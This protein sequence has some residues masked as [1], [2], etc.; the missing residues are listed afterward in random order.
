MRSVRKYI[1]KRGSDSKTFHTMKYSLHTV[2]NAQ[3][4]YQLDCGW[5]MNLFLTCVVDDFAA[6]LIIITSQ[7]P[8]NHHVRRSTMDYGKGN[9]IMSLI[10]YFIMVLSSWVMGEHHEWMNLRDV[11]KIHWDN[12]RRTDDAL[13]IAIKSQEPRAKLWSTAP[14]MLHSIILKEC[15]WHMLD[16][17]VSD[18]DSLIRYE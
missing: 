11:A 7:T 12:E 18:V 1:G 16:A 6:I 8:L 17:S 4:N 2:S 9:S 14:P 13:P 10:S 15:Y 5:D 3:K